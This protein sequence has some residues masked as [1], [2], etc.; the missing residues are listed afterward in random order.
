MSDTSGTVSAIMGKVMPV[1]DKFQQNIYVSSITGG[2]MGG[3][4]V[5]MAGAILQL[6]Y[7]LPIEPW[8][9]FL[10][11]TGLYAL[12]TTVVNIFNMTALVFA[13]TI[14]YSFGGKKGVDQLQCAIAG[15]MAFL[16]VTPLITDA[17]TGAVTISTG[18]FGAQ[19][20]F[21][22]MICSLV[23]STIY[24]FCIKRNL[25]IRLPE[26]VPDF[27]DKCLSP[28][29]TGVL[30]MIPFIALRGVFSMTD[31]GS[32][33]DFIYAVIQTP[34]TGLGNTLPAHLIALVA[35]SLLWWCGVHGSL[36]A[37]SVLTAVL[38]PPML[39]NLAAY[40]A[41]DPIPFVLSYMSLFMVFQFIGGPGCM[42]GLYL[43]LAFTTKSERYKAQ[44]KI[45]LVPGIFNIIEPT[46]FGLPVM[47]NVILLIP[48]VALPVIVYLLYYFLASA[49]II[50]IPVLSLQ[51]M[52][53]PGPIAGFLLGGGISLGIF[54]LA[55][56]VLSCIVYYPFVKI[57]DRQALAEEKAAA[58][59]KAAEAD[60]EPALEA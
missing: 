49:G 32:M 48:F 20:I 24:A 53:L 52:V 46:V 58:E 45:S 40:N 19:G 14:G 36:V 59:A 18:Y 23:A 55:M 41:G 34:L 43:D 37:L 33:T 9:N 35:I 1:I 13:F 25:V 30:T 44:G 42:F 3:L 50:G 26:S 51:V 5:M 2:M 4:T 28:I 16:I 21:T 29:P 54:V 57:L 22:A 15:F 11:S 38:T 7:G 56:C 6:F 60:T 12:C 27:V 17:E 8:T 47:M 39:E 10:Q 31:F